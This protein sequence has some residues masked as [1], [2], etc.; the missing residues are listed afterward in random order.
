MAVDGVCQKTRYVKDIK[1][2]RFA[3]AASHLQTDLGGI[4]VVENDAYRE[5]MQT[6]RDLHSWW[7]KEWKS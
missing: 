2:W 7:R 5:L 6:A 4:D 3:L 1:G